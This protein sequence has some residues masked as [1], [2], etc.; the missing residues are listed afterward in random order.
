[1]AKT[2]KPFIR[3]D[4]PMSETIREN[5]RFAY[6][7]RIR[8]FATV[9]VIA[10]HSFHSYFSAP[11]NYGHLLWTLLAF[12]NEITR[13]AVPLFFMISGYLTLSRDIP[14]IPAFYKKKLL[15]IGLPFIIYDVFYYVIS[16]IDFGTVPSV[17]G[18]FKGLLNSGNAYHLW[19]VYSILAMYLLAPFLR[20]LVV[21]CNIKQ[22]WLLFALS[23][24]QTTIRPFINVFLSKLG[25]GLYL[26]DDGFMGYVGYF[27]LGYILGTYCNGKNFR[28]ACII[29]AVL[30]FIVFPIITVDLIKSG[31]SS[32]FI[33]GYAVNHYVEAAGI[34][35]FF[36]H[37][38]K[39]SNRV[40]KILSNVSFNAYLVHV[41]V[42]NMLSKLIAELQP[43]KLILL[44]VLVTCAV[45][46]AWGLVVRLAL[47]LVKLAKD[48]AHLASAQ[49]RERRLR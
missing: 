39:K 31:E 45:S 16:T 44:N 28:R 32:S 46:F 19:F 49:F 41:F 48:K 38:F 11:S 3:R 24:F 12:V 6:L 33:G 43:Y 29:L 8:V 15:K 7:D 30:S 42:L 1:M 9:G 18:Y 4:S 36:K 27:L 22:L 23:I 35:L 5:G 26:A 13:T 37:G 20:R 34:F 2:V 40:V 17:K 47:V 25:V 10:L 21:S 14:D